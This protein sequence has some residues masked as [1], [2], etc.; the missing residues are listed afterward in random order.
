MRSPTARHQD[1]R[2]AKKFRPKQVG[3]LSSAPI[4]I[5]WSL[6]TPVISLLSSFEPSWNSEP[7]DLAARAG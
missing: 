6:V 1:A 7:G 3:N 4:M 5:V 2:R